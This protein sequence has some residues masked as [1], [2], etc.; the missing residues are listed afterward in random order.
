MIMKRKILVAAWLL[1]VGLPL[2]AQQIEGKY[3]E[4][5]GTSEIE[6]VPD[7]IHYVIEIREYFQ[8]EFDGKSKPEEYRTKVPLSTIEEELRKTLASIGI[9][10]SAIRTQ[11]IGNGWRQNGQEF[12]VSKQLN[13][14]LQDFRKIEA[15]TRQ[16]NSRGI[17][18]M[19]IGELK[20]KEMATYQRQGRIEA[21]Q[22]A[23]QKAAYLVEALGKK[24][25]SV[26][27]IV[28]QQE[29][30]ALFGWRSP[31]SNVSLSETGSFDAYRTLKKSYSM[32]VRFEIAD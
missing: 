20:N 27:R 21:L 14:T 17:T 19:H 32:Q 18:N 24:L 6:I 2:Q 1:A 9:P 13:L 4:V 5:T 12:L 28:E 16:I 31:Q 23:R 22:A 7:E 10:S 3:I 15:I 8:E 25:G 11:E 26:V 29:N 30:P